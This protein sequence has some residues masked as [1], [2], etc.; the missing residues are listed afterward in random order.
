MFPIAAL[1]CN[2]SLIGFN[3]HFLG[4]CLQSAPLYSNE[5]PYTIFIPITVAG[6]IVRFFLGEDDWQCN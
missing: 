5:E 6:V 3:L 1:W 4:I 2:E